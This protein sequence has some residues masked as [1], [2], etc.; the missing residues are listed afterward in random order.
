MR[1]EIEKLIPELSE[2]KDDEI[3]EKT[4]RVW[5]QALERGGWTPEDL[6]HIPFTLLVDEVPITFLEHVRTVCRLCIR[7]AE[8]LSEAYGERVRIDRDVLVAG[9][10]IAD[11]GKLLEYTRQGNAIV[12]SRSGRYLRHPFTGVALGFEQGLPDEILHVAAVHSKE[13]EG[14][15][16]SPEAI[17]FHHADFTD[18]ELVQ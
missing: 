6:H 3:R 15:K 17:I 5:V 18:F 11:V 7:T 4:T 2:I 12:K 14:F 8:V 1:E 9:A 13:G 10:L 16:R